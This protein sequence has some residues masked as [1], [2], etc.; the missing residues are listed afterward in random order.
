[1]SKS[2]LTPDA[3]WQLES[4]F[5]YGGDFV[6]IEKAQA[7]IDGLETEVRGLLS[8]NKSLQTYG[9]VAIGTW[10]EVKTENQALREL[11]LEI[12]YNIAREY[13]GEPFKNICKRIDE[14]LK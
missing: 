6:R 4:G 1:M 11:L 13:F 5:P 8:K 2:P 3:H 12:R 9:D 14:V 10:E 7:M